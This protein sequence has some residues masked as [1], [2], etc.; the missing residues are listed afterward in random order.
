MYAQGHSCCYYVYCQKL[1]AICWAAS[2]RLCLCAAC[3]TDSLLVLSALSA[4]HGQIMP[5][6]AHLQYMTISFQHFLSGECDDAAA[7][8]R[9][10]GRCTLQ[11]LRHVLGTDVMRRVQQAGAG[12][13]DA[14]GTIAR[15]FQQWSRLLHVRMIGWYG[16][17]AG[18][19][20]IT[21]MCCHCPTIHVLLDMSCRV[22][23]AMMVTKHLRLQYNQWMLSEA[24]NLD[25]LDGWT[26]RTVWKRSCLSTEAEPRSERINH[27]E[28][29]LPLNC[30][31]Q[32]LDDVVCM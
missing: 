3:H 22:L 13:Q 30:Q 24:L 18:R 4:A 19:M 23:P 32:V 10:A 28:G 26:G 16:W 6:P 7:C 12:W 27:S 14:A 21:V 8:F 25:Y 2:V 29:P 11:C 9:V 17:R 5:S 31:G 15:E 20:V 1:P